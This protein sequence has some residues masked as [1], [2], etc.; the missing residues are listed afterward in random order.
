[1]FM[2]SGIAMVIIAVEFLAGGV[3][4]IAVVALI[5]RSK[6]RVGLALRAALFAGLAFLAM[7]GASGWAGAQAEFINGQRQDVTSWGEHLWLRNRLSA[8]EIPLCIGSSI[9]A[10]ALTSV[11]SRRTSSQ[12]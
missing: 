12:E 4:G 9:A 6:L 7:A 2:T 10:A 1:M 3:I 8:Y 11:F 5:F